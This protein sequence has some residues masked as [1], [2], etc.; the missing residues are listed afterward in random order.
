MTHVI[1]TGLICVFLILSAVSYI[2]HQATIEGVRALGFPDFFRIQLAILKIAASLV[3]M[4]PFIG[5]QVK[6]WAYVGVVLFLITA[7]VAHHVH[8]DPIL[9]NMLNVLVFIVLITSYISR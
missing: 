1:S 2:F 3:L 5:M 7:I 9:F 8:D 6:E 4:A